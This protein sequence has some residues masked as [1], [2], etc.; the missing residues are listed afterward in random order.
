MAQ[1]LGVSRAT[2]RRDLALLGRDGR[3][4]RIYGGAVVNADDEPPFAA[5]ATERV[6]DKDAVARRA[7][8]LVGDGEVLLLD[9][10]TTVLRFARQLHGRA[11]T[12]ITSNLAVY[13][14]LA[15]DPAV[16]LVLLGGLVRRNYRSLVGFLTEDCVRQVHAERLFLGA[17]GV[18]ADGRVMD[19]TVIEVPVKRAMI[20]AADQVVL[21]AD[22]A[23]FPGGG[24]ARVC[25]SEDVDAVVTNASAD[26]CALDRLRE[27]GV[28]VLEA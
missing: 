1:R 22:A 25:G 13:E 7:A 23:K 6:E 11:V 15:A 28:E 20:A 8:Q 26:R 12:V 17:S 10:G 16:Q 18:R 3:V 9:V 5:V 21:L 19:T 4:T 2:V 24:F 27:L 14:E